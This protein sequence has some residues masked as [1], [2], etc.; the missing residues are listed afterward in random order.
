ML[1]KAPSV[2]AE[3]FVNMCAIAKQGS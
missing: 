1:S 3:N 2:N